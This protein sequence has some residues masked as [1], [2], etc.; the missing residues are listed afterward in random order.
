MRVVVTMTALIL[1][2]G[3][4]SAAPEVVEDFLL[5]AVDQPLPNNWRLAVA[6]GHVGRGGA[7]YR[8]SGY[9]HVLSLS[10]SDIQETAQGMQSTQPLTVTTVPPQP[11][12]ELRAWL[13]AMGRYCQG[14]QLTDEEWQVIDAHGGPK[15]IPSIFQG[16]CSPVK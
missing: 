8:I 7:A 3:A 14:E 11:S 9:E 2:L 5:P 1:G 10:S 13:L 4:C 16:R 12:S 6:F 15:N